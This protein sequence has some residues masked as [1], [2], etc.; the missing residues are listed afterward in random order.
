M[1][2]ENK[3]TKK[4]EQIIKKKISSINL[5]TTTAPIIILCDLQATEKNSTTTT[6][7]GQTTNKTLSTT[8]M[9]PMIY[10]YQVEGRKR[11][12]IQVLDL[13][14]TQQ[15]GLVQ[16]PTCRE[17]TSR[18]DPSQKINNIMSI[19]HFYGRTNKYT[20]PR[21]KNETDELAQGFCQEMRFSIVSRQHN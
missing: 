8:Y 10:T 11:A 20:F 13:W 3:Q 16:I 18:I 15:L 6:A 4:D 12:K 2:E 19:K 9:I 7:S 5:L 1:S 17:T 21:E 14:P